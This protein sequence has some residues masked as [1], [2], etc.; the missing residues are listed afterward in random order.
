MTI[1][2]AS[3]SSKK[4]D[5]EDEWDLSHLAPDYTWKKFKEAV[6]WGPDQR[7]AREAYDKGQGLF[8]EAVSAAKNNDEAAKLKNYEEAAKQFYI[9][10]WRW[11]DSTMEE[12]AMFLM[13]ESYFFMDQ[14]GTAQDSYTNLLK[15]H[16]NTRYLD[17]VVRRLFTI[18]EY[19]EKLDLQTHHWPVTPN[20]IDK[21]Q[22]WFDT[23]GNAMACYHA[24]WMHDPTGPMADAALFRVANAH[25]RRGEW[26]DAA[27]HYDML[28]KNHPKS[29][30][31]KDAHILELQAKERIYQGPKYSVVPLNDAQEIAEQALKQFPG[32]LGE[33]ER[34]VRE[35]LSFIHEQR[36]EREW[37][38]AQYYDNK[39]E[40][41]AA[42][43]YYKYLV[44]KYPQTAF[45]QRAKQ[46]MQEIQNEPDE[47]PNHFKW[48]AAPFGDGK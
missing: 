43:E 15:A 25:F 40:Y 4:S 48:L 13:A 11:P 33:E 37:V 19:W 31:Q 16:D 22:P 8:N 2:P 47:P 36:A 21:T 45:A 12:D 23:F 14:Y 28:R 38:M 18:G 42:R 44:Q 39:S 41:R 32:Q 46:R 27:E 17:T 30:F 3:D 35:T 24:V 29:K 20:M 7:L 6:G 5:D 34:R 10:T 9:A 1:G 26:E